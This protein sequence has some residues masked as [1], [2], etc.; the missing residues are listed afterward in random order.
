MLVRVDF[1]RSMRKDRGGGAR[2]LL[3]HRTFGA[4]KKMSASPLLVISDQK[5]PVEKSE[6]EGFLLLPS[7]FLGAPRA[8]ESFR[9]SLVRR[10]LSSI[11]AAFHA[12]LK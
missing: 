1:A 3:R 11:A 7:V 5:L 12:T 9:S 6:S 4:V 8:R 2:L 10:R